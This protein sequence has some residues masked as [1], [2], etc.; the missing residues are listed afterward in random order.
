MRFSIVYHQ[1]LFCAG[2]CIG[3]PAW[4]DNE[5]NF[6]QKL[7]EMDKVAALADF[8]TTQKQACLK[9]F[10]LRYQSQYTL[11]GALT[12]DEPLSLGTYDRLFWKGEGSL[13]R[14]L[15]FTGS[16]TDRSGAKAGNL[17]CYYAT[18]NDRLDFQ[19]AYVLPL[20]TKGKVVASNENS[21][22]AS[23]IIPSSKE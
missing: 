17:I 15:I 6:R 13:H 8:D 21:N 16:V 9:A 10:N 7:F 19:S 11:S 18:T 14:G 23:L 4:A 22:Q 20:K 12:F 2:L 3:S 1:I 5:S